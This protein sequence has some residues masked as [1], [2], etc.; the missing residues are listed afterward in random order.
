MAGDDRRVLREDHPEPLR[1]Q[2]SA[3]EL[4]PVHGADRGDD[5]SMAEGV[6]AARMQGEAGPELAVRE[7]CEGGEGAIMIAVA[8]TQDQR[9]RPTRID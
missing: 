3:V 1:L 5:D 2:R 6:L 8:V 9:V 7:A 4:A